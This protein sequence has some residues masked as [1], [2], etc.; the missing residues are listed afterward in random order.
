MLVL[1]TSLCLLLFRIALAALY[2]PVQDGSIL[3][4]GMPPMRVDPTWDAVGGVPIKR[5]AHAH[6]QLTSPSDEVMSAGIVDGAEPF[7]PGL[8]GGG[9]S[10]PAEQMDKNSKL[11]L[12]EFLLQEHNKGR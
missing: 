3:R 5:G 11:Q 7:G 2:V 9:N 12:A 4:P 6:T 10:A 1:P 8:R